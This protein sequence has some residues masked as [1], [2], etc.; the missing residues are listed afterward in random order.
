MGEFCGHECGAAYKGCVYCDLNRAKRRISELQKQ[1]KDYASELSVAEAEF[2]A[3]QTKLAA[4]EK[5]VAFYKCCALSGETPKPG[6]EP[7]AALKEQDDGS[8]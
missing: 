3:L 8:D 1:I 5:D 4:S 6:S 2:K 7:S